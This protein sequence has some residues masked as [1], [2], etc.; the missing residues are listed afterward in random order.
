MIRAADPFRIIH[1]ERGF[2]VQN[3]EGGRECRVREEDS[4]RSYMAAHLTATSFASHVARCVQKQLLQFDR[5]AAIH[6]DCSQNVFHLYGYT[7]GKMFSLLLTLAEV[8]EWKAAGP[9]ALD[10]YIFGQ[11]AAKGI[12]LVHMTPYL[13]AVFSQ[14]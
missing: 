8:E 13:R 3:K 1:S 12:S 10:R 2:Y 14:V 9:Y 6:F 4:L 11:L 5:Q 7:Q